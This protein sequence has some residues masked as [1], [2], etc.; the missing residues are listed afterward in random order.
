MYY[1]KLSQAYFYS[2]D[3]LQTLLVIIE[4]IWYLKYISE[5]LKQLA[6]ILDLNPISRQ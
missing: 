2:I 1:Y 5:L 4:V 3:E 6:I